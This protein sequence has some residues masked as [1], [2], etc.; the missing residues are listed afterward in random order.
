MRDYDTLFGRVLHSRDRDAAW[1]G[2]FKDVTFYLSFSTMYD[3][4]QKC[5]VTYDENLGRVCNFG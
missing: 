2:Y 1:L 5:H 3:Y 4:F